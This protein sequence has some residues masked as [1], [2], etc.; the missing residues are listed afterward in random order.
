MAADDPNPTASLADLASFKGAELTGVNVWKFG[1]TL[2]FNDGSRTITVESGIEFR[3]Q[4][5]TEVYNQEII[6]AF[7]R[8]AFGRKPTAAEQKAATELITQAPTLK[9]GLEDLLWTL[10]NCKEFLFNH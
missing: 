7:Y 9:E 4:G 10:C 2:A 5:R 6:V 1:V 3:S 8:A